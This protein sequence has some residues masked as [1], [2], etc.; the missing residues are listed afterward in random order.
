MFGGC[1]KRSRPIPPIPGSSGLCGV[2]GTGW[3]CHDAGV[4]VT[5]SLSSILIALMWAGIGGVLAW[6]VNYPGARRS[7]GGLLA[8]VVLTATTAAVAGVLGSVH[9]MSLPKH[10]EWSA[11]M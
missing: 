11:I 5:P 1:A 3:N 7:L 4:A 6:L 8:A 10:E 2:S 9:E